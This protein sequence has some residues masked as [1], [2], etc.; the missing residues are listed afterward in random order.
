M[1]SLLLKKNGFI[2]VLFIFCS[3]Y[4][5]IKAQHR[6]FAVIAGVSDYK[7]DAYDLDLNYCDDDARLFY[8]LLRSSG[9]PSSNMVLLIDALASKKK[10]IASLKQTFNKAGSVDEVIYYFSGHGGDGYFLPYD[11]MP[12]NVLYHSEVKAAFKSCKATKKLCIAD[13]CFSG[14]IK[15]KRGTSENTNSMNT[16]AD[17]AVMMSLRN[18]QSSLEYGGYIEHGVFTYCLVQGLK[19]YADKNNDKTITVSEMYYYT[20]DKVM[21]KT[22]NKQTP[23]IFGKFDKN[24]P[25]LYLK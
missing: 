15:E 7:N 12:G 25:I 16:S 17:I 5:V 4:D 24:M 22:Q 20:R 11:Y 8:N 19:G 23:I 21:D 18:N 2:I 10:I 14:S 3:S 1:K 9:V 6:V 13:A